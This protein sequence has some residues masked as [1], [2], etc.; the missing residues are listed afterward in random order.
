MPE[1]EKLLKERIAFSYLLEV[2]EKYKVLHPV[3]NFQFEYH[4][5]RNSQSFSHMTLSVF[6]YSYSFTNH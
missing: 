2:V 3:N 5:H 4:F 1:D 6:F